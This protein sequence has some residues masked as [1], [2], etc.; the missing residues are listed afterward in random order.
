MNLGANKLTLKKLNA[1]DTWINLANEHY[2]IYKSVNRLLN[3]GMQHA[4]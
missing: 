4:A 2:L 1:Y 3:G